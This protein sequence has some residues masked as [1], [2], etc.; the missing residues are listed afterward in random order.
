MTIKYVKLKS[1][2][3]SLNLVI[4][5]DV[6]FTKVLEEVAILASESKKFF[7]DKTLDFVYSGVKLT[8]E[9]QVQL[10]RCFE[11]NAECCIASMISEDEKKEIKKDSSEYIGIEEMPTKL[12]RGTLRSGFLLEYEGNILIL[13][14]VNP[15]AEI[16]A[17][18]SIIVFGNLKGKVFAGKDG[19]DN[20][21]VIASNF[22]P[23][24][25]R[26]ADKITRRPDNETELN[27]KRNTEISFIEDD[28]ICIEEYFK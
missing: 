13:G 18:G 9:K 25:L 23:V 22:N 28:I 5:S 26:I 19:N 3:K 8:A 20:A 16:K 24:Q 12:Y 6:L 1:V 15:G 11:D 27:K 2:K 21:Y 14:D 10:R 4:E 7:K 17:T